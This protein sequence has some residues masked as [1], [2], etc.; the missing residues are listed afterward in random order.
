MSK[1]SLLLDNQASTGSR[2][3]RHDSSGGSGLSEKSFGKSSNNLK[4]LA[5]TI[6]QHEV[7]PIDVTQNLLQVALQ[8][9]QQSGS[10]KVTD[11]S[12][13]KIISREDIR[14]LDCVTSYDRSQGRYQLRRS[15]QNRITASIEGGNQFA[16]LAMIVLANVAEETAI[17]SKM[18]ATHLSPEPQTRRQAMLGVKADEWLAAEQLEIIS[19]RENNVFTG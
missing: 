17:S 2:K 16:A 15:V 12:T 7:L 13:R 11:V 14:N 8:A 18:Y 5:S 19:M 1:S 3:S 9:K 6:P 10:S 4:S